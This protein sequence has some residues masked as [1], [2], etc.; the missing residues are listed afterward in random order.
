MKETSKM[1]QVVLAIFMTNSKDKASLS[2]IEFIHAWA[3]SLVSIP[4]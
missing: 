2:Y 1:Y 3:E 4:N